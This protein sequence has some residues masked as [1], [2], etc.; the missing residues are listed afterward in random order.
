[1]TLHK[2]R[3]R[4]DDD[5]DVSQIQNMSTPNINGENAQELVFNNSQDLNTT[6]G[7]DSALNPI[8]LKENCLQQSASSTHHLQPPSLLETA[9]YYMAWNLHILYRCS[10]IL[11]KSAFTA[12]HGIELICP[13]PLEPTYNIQ[14]TLYDNI[15]VDSKVKEYLFKQ[16]HKRK[17]KVVLNQLTNDVI[18]QWKPVT[19]ESWNHLDPFFR[20]RR[21]R[22]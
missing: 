11:P 18:Q 6:V 8:S 17:Y 19:H 13:S 21:H 16:A 22:F 1:M 5:G 12:L 15:K 7:Y 9:V 10:M 20:N 2:K 3:D 4:L 14:V